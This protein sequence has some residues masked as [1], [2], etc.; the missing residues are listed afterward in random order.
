M[1]DQIP[2]SQEDLETHRFLLAEAADSQRACEA[3]W[4]LLSR[5]PE[6]I[7]EDVAFSLSMAIETLWNVAGGHVLGQPT[8]PFV[9]KVADLCHVKIKLVLPNIKGTKNTIVL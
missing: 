4:E 3:L 1:I 6:D 9:L 7:I 2:F 8:W 5:L